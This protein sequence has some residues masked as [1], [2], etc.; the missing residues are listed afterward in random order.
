MK[1]V[2]GRGRGGAYAQKGF[3]VLRVFLCGRL[4]FLRK[5]SEGRRELLF[6]VEELDD[7]RG[8]PE[9]NNLYVA[10]IVRDLVPH[11]E[12]VVCCYSAFEP[13]LVLRPPHLH[14]HATVRLCLAAL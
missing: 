3:F 8:R 12:R 6:A 2:R 14:P 1:G 11:I 10:V 4:L 7:L 5:T 9:R 13:L